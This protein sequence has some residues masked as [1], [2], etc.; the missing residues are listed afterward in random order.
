MIMPLERSCA[1]LWAGGLLVQ[2]NSDRR[3]PMDIR[4]TATRIAR[5]F[6]TVEDVEHAATLSMLGQHGHI[7]EHPRDCPAWQESCPGSP[8]THRTRLSW[9][10]EDT[11]DVI[12]GDADQ[13]DATEIHG[14]TTP[15]DIEEQIESV[16]RAQDALARCRQRLAALCVDA[17]TPLIVC[18][19][20]LEWHHDQIIQWINRIQFDDNTKNVAHLLIEERGIEINERLRQLTHEHP[21]KWR[22]LDSED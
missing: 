4:L 12:G 7:F 10:S 6:P 14:K 21:V 8:L 15:E 1:V 13:P 9:P 5:H 11:D 18:F 3:V 20:V 19:H 17:H 22:P 2:L 16:N